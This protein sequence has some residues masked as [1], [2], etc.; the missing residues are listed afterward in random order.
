[1]T[2]SLSLNTQAILLLTAPLLMGRNQAVAELL[3]PGEYRQLA[4]RLHELQ[5]Q[6]SDLIAQD[7]SALIKECGAGIDCSIMLILF[8]HGTP[9]SIA[10]WLEGHAVV[11]A[12]TRGWDSLV[13]GELLNA[14]E[15]PEGSEPPVSV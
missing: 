3:T 10:R 14:A 8:D 6:P 7:A 4:R 1:M 13:N 9:R 12:I 2:H 5:R 15:D 11:E